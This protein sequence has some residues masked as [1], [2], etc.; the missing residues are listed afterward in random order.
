MA[1]KTFTTETLDA[2]EVNDY[3]MTQVIIRCTSG[4]RPS[5]PSEGWHIY[6]TDTQRLLGYRGGS[7]VPY[8]IAPVQHSFQAGYKKYTVGTEQLVGGELSIDLEPNK[9][10]YFDSHIGVMQYT[11]GAA[12][13][14]IDIIVTIP[15]G[16]TG[17][18]FRNSS[19]DM[20]VGQ[21]TGLHN[22]LS[23]W[24]EIQYPGTELRTW[25]LTVI[26]L[27]PTYF[28]AQRRCGI[29]RTQSEGGKLQIFLRPVSNPDMEEIWTHRGSWIRAREIQVI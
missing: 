13:S 24:N 4:T 22:T 21:G 28:I 23:T 11:P 17:T 3:L 8:G 25:D 19:V 16:A 9:R 26:P 14:W 29:I 12:I 1:F 20:S 2:S 7:W 6:E 10:Y 18:L 27:F 15:P 5:S